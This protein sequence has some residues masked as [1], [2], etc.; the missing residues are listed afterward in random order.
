MVCLK[1]KNK[2]I[3]KKYNREILGIII[4]AFGVLS[5]ISLFS[6][7]TGI[8]GIF[9]KNIYL[10]LMGFGGYIFPLIIIVIG[11]LFIVNRLNSNEFIKS[12]YLLIMFLCLLTLL[13][14]RNQGDIDFSIRVKQS[15]SLGQEELAGGFIGVILDHCSISYLVL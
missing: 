5:T 10:T 1:G 3:S 2:L 15:L 11:G 7:K 8:I 13:D 12:V 4:V 14:I 6:D 9:L